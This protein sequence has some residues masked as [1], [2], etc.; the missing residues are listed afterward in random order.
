MYKNRYAGHVKSRPYCSVHKQDIY[1]GTW[2]IYQNSLPLFLSVS[3]CHRLWDEFSR[4]TLFI[5]E[6]LSSGRRSGSGGVVSGYL[7]PPDRLAMHAAQNRAAGRPQT[8]AECCP[9]SKKSRQIYALLSSQTR[10]CWEPVSAIQ[11]WRGVMADRDTT[12]LTDWMENR[13]GDSS[14]RIIT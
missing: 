14:S 10:P 9:W 6:A 3:L 7:S 8:G 13:T 4:L 5:M 2:M 1:F 12:R 11:R